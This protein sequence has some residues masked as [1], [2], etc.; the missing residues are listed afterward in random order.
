MNYSGWR[1]SVTRG[2]KIHRGEESRIFSF[3]VLHVLLSLVIG[4]ISTVVDPLVIV[5]RS[6]DTS[7]VMYSFS[8]LVLFVI[9]LFYAGV[10]DRIDKRRLFSLVLLVSLAVCVAAG[11]LLFL[12]DAVGGVPFLLPA[13]FVWRFV[14]GILLLLVFWDLAP[15]FFDARQGK[16]LFPLLAIGGAIGYSGGSLIVVPVARILPLGFQLF[17]IGLVTVLCIISFR[18]IRG[19]FTILDSPRYRNRTITEELREGMKAFRGNGFLRAV[20]WNTIIFG[21]LSGLI[22]LTYNSVI[23]ARTSTGSE[24][25]SLMGFQRAAATILQAVVLTKVMSQSALGGKH[26]NAVVMQILFF[27]LGI[28]AFAIS[29][30]G[31]A[32]FTRQ[33]EVALMSPAAMAA[34]AFLPS[35]YR[36]RVMV[37]NN[38][39]AAALGILASTVFVML[40]MPYVDP[41]W[42]IYPIG[43]LMVVRLGFNFVLNRRYVALLSENLL[44]NNRINLA[45]IEEN[46]G[47]ILQDEAL[48][49]RLLE[50]TRGQSPSIRLFVTGRL[51]RSAT[52]V[53]DMESISPFFDWGDEKNET[54]EALRIQTLARI[55]FEN[56]QEVIRDGLKSSFSSVRVASRLAILTRR[57]KQ[58]SGEALQTE[59]T[60]LRDE[61]ERLAATGTE[62]Q[63]RE[64][65][66]LVLKLEGKI[67][68]RIAAAA[69]ETLHPSRQQIFLTAIAENP[70]RYYMPLLMDR[71]HDEPFQATALKGLRRMP[72]EL[73]L[74]HREQL[75]SLGLRERLLLLKEM[76]H[77][78]PVFTRL[79]STDL[80][81]ALLQPLLTRSAPEKASETA[82]GATITGATITDAAAP[83]ELYRLLHRDGAALTDA[84]LLVLSDP[85]PVSTALS[86]R[87][88]EAAMTLTSLYPVLFSLRFETP[89][90]ERAAYEPLYTKL[91]DERLR[92]LS[93]LVLTL[94]S[95]TLKKEDDRVLAWSICRELRDR[96]SPVKQNALEFIETRTSDE[97][98]KYLLLFFEK[99]TAGEK[100]ARLRSLTKNLTIDYREILA[101]L[102]RRY[103]SVG[104]T[105]SAEILESIPVR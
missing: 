50:E 4:M 93:V 23:D 84:T 56:Y 104:D 80:L 27:T 96:M 14:V 31:V 86:R 8:A 34:F 67:N 91:L 100:R 25:A 105:V 70:N 37:L 45:R 26:K 90:M 6:G 74:E 10:T 49:Q 98:R 63:F 65:S 38:I 30:V 66:E 17:T 48:V 61:F 28:A 68:Q 57:F 33:I 72:E 76:Q 99:L 13:L 36:G 83:E 51:A 101:D 62:D 42:F 29:M 32:D 41:L 87:I 78:H 73:L 103:S 92:D 7:V 9:G 21:F 94:V 47:S 53:Q 39:T 81:E 102:A 69:W 12:H 2:L 77:T 60:S 89:G 11:L 85:A 1:L 97:T 44:S 5:H 46:T 64:I 40:T 18:F 95:A 3:F 16:R 15:F 19:R 71:L 58:E 20:G 82:T 35:R 75:A 54:L 88:E 59:L 43:A 79:E 52:T 22:I 24:A 55:D